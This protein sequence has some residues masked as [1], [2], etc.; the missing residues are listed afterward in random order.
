MSDLRNQTPSTTY[1][2]LLQVNDYSNGV[3]ATSKFVQDGEGTNSALSI[4]TTKVGV[5]TSSPSAPLD[6]T[7]TTGG[8]VFPRLTTTQRDAISSPTNGETIYNTT[9]TQVESY[10][11]TAWV[12]GGATVVGTNAVTSNSIA[13][14]AII[15][16]KI[17]NDAVTTAKIANDA[18]T[19]D[20][21][22]PNI[23][24]PSGGLELGTNG[25]KIATSASALNVV[26]RLNA[27]TGI[28]LN[29]GTSHVARNADQITVTDKFKTIAE[30]YQWL[31]DNISSTGISVDIVIET[32]ITETASTAYFVRTTDD[33]L[34]TVRF[35][36]QGL[37]DNLGTPSATQI[38]PPVVTINVDQNS[39]FASR[40]IFWFGN[41]TVFRGIHFVANYG[42]K[43]GEYHAFARALGCRV[44]FIYSKITLTSSV[45]TN[46]VLE[47]VNNAL[48]RVTSD[49]YA[50]TTNGHE[51]PFTN[52]GR[53]HGLEIDVTGCTG[54]GFC[55]GV[56]NQ[57]AFEAVEFRSGA[58]RDLSGIHF[59]GN[60]TLA[61]NYF[62]DL[63]ASSRY[64]INTKVSRNSNTTITS[65][66]VFDGQG[67][68]TLTLDTY[69]EQGTTEYSKLPGTIAYASGFTTPED[70]SANATFGSSKASGPVATVS[71]DTEA[72]YF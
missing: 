47:S 66:S 68:N 58:D 31:N 4:S 39:S 32:N 24:D 9:T 26:L 6:V 21:L 11:G 33:R 67:Y 53:A 14:D 48:M 51:D 56:S 29:S 60:G 62:M 3:D 23:I 20:K 57:S 46:R 17:N 12:A 25:L 63:R 40:F 72:D 54:I 64:N 65:N 34:G 1:K 5:G 35:W 22:N 42:A 36:S 69:T 59:S 8:V 28:D 49:M 45:N 71:L 43:G 18:V 55:I 7:S 16:D 2:G 61:M 70:F 19:L 52:G 13:N 27:T 30:T 41:T 15:T 50:S 37:Y 10:N 44:T 38:T